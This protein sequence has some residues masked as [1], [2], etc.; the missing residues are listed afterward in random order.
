MGDAIKHKASFGECFIKTRIEG[1]FHLE[2]PTLEVKLIHPFILRLCHVHLNV[3]P[4]RN[5]GLSGDWV[6][7]I[8]TQYLI[9][10]VGISRRP[11]GNKYIIF[12][13]VYLDYKTVWSYL[14][15]TVVRTYCLRIT[16]SKDE[17]L[18]PLER[19]CFADI[20]IVRLLSYGLWKCILSIERHRTCIAAKIRSIYQGYDGWGFRSPY[21]RI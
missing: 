9:S 1:K 19:V 5:I 7:V 17:P 10:R 12:L 16:K 6:N 11:S 3:L 8:W 15:A 2:V 14:Q 4:K 18:L 13:N 21:N 20:R